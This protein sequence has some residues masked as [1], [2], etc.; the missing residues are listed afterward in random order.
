MTPLEQWLVNNFLEIAIIVA[1]GVWAFFKLN[2]RTG[3]VEKKIDDH[4]DPEADF[5]HAICRTE[6][7]NL[8]FIKGGLAEVKEKLDALDNRIVDLIKNGSYHRSPGAPEIQP[9]Q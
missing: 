4:L 2:G 7:A 3:A 5:P 8:E 9:K 1:G 6:S